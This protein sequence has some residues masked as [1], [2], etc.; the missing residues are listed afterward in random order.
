MKAIKSLFG[1]CLVLAIVFLPGGCNPAGGGGGVGGSTN[2]NTNGNTNTNTN[3]NGNGNDNSTPLEI[4]ESVGGEDAD[5]DF[6]DLGKT[7]VVR[8]SVGNGRHIVLATGQTLGFDLD[9][10]VRFC[11]VIPDNITMRDLTTGQD[12]PL[13]NDQLERI[14]F[15]DEFGEV[16]SSRV[17]I[18]LPDSL[19]AGH[20]YQVTLD[21]AT[22]GLDGDFQQNP[23]TSMASNGTLP[24]GDG[25][26]GGDFL[27]LFRTLSGITFLAGTNE[28][29]GMAL[30]ANDNLYVVSENGLFGPFDA[31]KD[32]TDGDRLAP[33]LPALAKRPIVVDNDG[34]VIVK[35]RSDGIIFEVNPV[36]GLSTQIAVADDLTSFPNDSVLAPAGYASVE[37]SAVEPGDVIFT[38][39]SDVTV[40]DRRGAMGRKGGVH[41]VDRDSGKISEAY[42]SL[43]VPPQRTGEDQVVYGAFTPEEG[44]A[45]EVHRLLPNG[46]VDRS[47]LTNPSSLAAVAGT[48][49]IKLDDIQGR[50]EYLILGRVDTSLVDLRQIL[51]DDFDGVAVMIYNETESR[52]Q[53][54]FP[55]ALDTFNFTS[56]GLFSDAVLTSDKNAVY[57]SLPSSSAVVEF[58]GFANGASSSGDPACDPSFDDDLA[59]APATGAA[60]VFRSTLGNGRH[61]L[62]STPTVLEFDI[63]Q[64]VPLCAVNANNITLRDLE[65]GQDV[66]LASRRIKRWLFTDDANGVS[67]GS[68]I[69]IDLPP[70]LVTG[71][72][73]EITLNA[74]ALGL[75]GEFSSGGVNGRLPSGD[76]VNG[77]DFVQVFQVIEG[78]YFLT[79]TGGAVGV[80]LDGDEALYAA[81]SESMFGPFTAPATPAPVTTLSVGSNPS[82][83]GQELTKAGKPMVAN[84]D[85]AAAALTYASLQNSR[86]YDADP[87]TG[88][89]QIFQTDFGQSGPG[90]F[91]VDMIEAPAGFAGDYLHIN[92]QRGV[93]I[94]VAASTTVALFTSN[95]QLLQFK[96]I[97]VAP[98][99]LFGETVYLAASDFVATTFSMLQIAADGTPTDEFA[100]LVGAT[101]E[102]GIRLQNY[103]G[104]GEYLILG[105]FDP[106]AAQLRTGQIRETSG[107]TE[108]ILYNPA[109]NRVQVIGS[110]SQGAD[111]TFTQDLETVYTSHPTLRAVL[112]LQGMGAAQP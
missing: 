33:N 103:M 4:C 71:S 73:Y 83:S 51:T 8:S 6:G 45:L 46:V 37:R 84:D 19:V 69:V 105:D 80:D 99:A 68:R 30:D 24:S 75:D 94:D 3:T 44:S 90:S 109:E 100:P 101:G 111:M 12:V 85:P 42:V 34:M 54:L 92:S 64:P 38:D 31:P 79:E 110:F 29:A 18:T 72:F 76:N 82:I 78:D 67:L 58:A 106:G 62:R 59:V 66:S 61:L 65:T 7:R 48:A 5:I 23:G 15:V 102:A 9:Q 17:Q 35:G 95:S 43:F 47:V 108:L 55:L 2:T 1:A 93:L 97:S 22:L 25:S 60:R 49:V 56:L 16:V 87:V 88:I 112:R 39:T 10:P 77:G 13:T 81:T 14:N 53:V 96:S 98:A 107:A 91:E 41:L 104:G 52:L 89:V 74:S 32:V 21:A 36:T 11:A 20:D 28:A 63:D 86:L 40:L 50:E 70:S 57:V 27:Q 26:A